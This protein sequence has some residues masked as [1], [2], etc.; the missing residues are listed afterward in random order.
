MKVNKT[1]LITGVS[2]GIGLAL[3]NNYFC[4]GWNVIGTIRDDVFID[5][6]RCKYRFEVVH[7]DLAL[8]TSINDIQKHLGDRTIDILVNN[9][10]IRGEEGAILDR[11]VN[12][13][14]D[15]LKVNCIAPINLVKNIYQNLEK[16]S[17]P[18]I[19]NISSI[20]GSIQG[21][22]S[23]GWCAY[24]ISKSSL[25]MLTRTMAIE[26]KEHNICCVAI[27]PGWVRTK[28]GGKRGVLSPVQCADKLF[29]TIGS[30]SMSDSGRFIDEEG[31]DI[32][33]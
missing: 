30:L 33:F 8:E 1:I 5:D 16:S 6:L 27:S 10:G 14:Y 26:F 15:I 7:L 13:Y 4:N 20:L 23:G 31:N 22:Y 29:N 12:E 25:N 3:A 11:D 32:P 24:R 18:Y 19:I 28:I 21:N 17:N 2:S 9:A